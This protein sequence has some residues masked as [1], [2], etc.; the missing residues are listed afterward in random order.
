MSQLVSEFWK[1]FTLRLR[2]EEMPYSKYLLHFLLLIVFVEKNFANFWFIRIMQNFASVEAQSRMQHFTLFSSIL[3]VTISLGFMFG[4]ISTLLYFW[5]MSNRAIQ[6]FTSMLALELIITSLFILWVACFAI[7]P[8]NLVQ[9]EFI[10][11]VLILTFILLLY[12]QFMVY[13]HIFAN[14]FSVTLL[15]AGI[16]AFSYMLL[17]H[18][19]SEII[20]TSLS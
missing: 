3:S 11:L 6:I 16:I 20:L 10:S 15:E 9:T 2:P 7:M 1:L 8:I 18:N 13:I 5:R 17:Q 19:V 4:A 14:A 12:W